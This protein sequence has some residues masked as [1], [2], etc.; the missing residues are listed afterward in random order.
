[1]YNCRTTSYDSWRDRLVSHDR[2]GKTHSTAGV[3]VS[4]STPTK[5]ARSIHRHPV[6]H[7]TF[8]QGQYDT[9]RYDTRV[10]GGLKSLVCSAWSSSTHAQSEKYKKKLKQTPV[11]T[12][13]NAG[14]RSVEAVRKKSVTGG[15]TISNNKLYIFKNRPKP[16]IQLSHT[17]WVLVWRTMYAVTTQMYNS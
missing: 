2:A 9:I 1:M 6:A 13:F 5:T 17:V 4:F 3:S 12:S 16:V 14:S 10:Q 11:P 7:A 8:P 15:S